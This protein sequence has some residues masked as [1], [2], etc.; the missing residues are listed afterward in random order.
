[1]KT[2][3][4]K[5]KK[6][7]LLKLCQIT[8]LLIGSASFTIQAAPTVFMGPVNDWM[9]FNDGSYARSFRSASF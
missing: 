2:N 9:E 3:P 8:A 1:M 4:Y 6:P 7:I 5:N